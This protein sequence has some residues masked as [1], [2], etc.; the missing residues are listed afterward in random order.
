[1]SVPGLVF[2]LEIR[3]SPE[4]IWEAIT[5]PDWTRRYF[6]GSA[7]R[8]D[9]RSGGKVT[10][11]TEDGRTA[12]DGEILEIDPPWRLVTTW[13]SLWEPELATEG[14]SRVTWEIVE[15]SDSCL[16]RVTHEGLEEAPKTRDAVSSGWPILIRGMRDCL[17]RSPAG[18]IA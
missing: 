2:E 12:C 7:V 14:P 15:R 18:A 9:W 8:G 3:S 13:R 11:A 5:S 1:M 6:F 10:W 4:R 17:E 16:L